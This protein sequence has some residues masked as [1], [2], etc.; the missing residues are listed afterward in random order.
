[1]HLQFFDGNPN[2]YSELHDE[3]YIDD[4]DQLDVAISDIRGAALASGEY[5]KGDRVWFI[6]WDEYNEHH[7]K[8]GSFKI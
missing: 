7:E 6:L 4:V 3:T 8:N 5:E 1:M 2:D